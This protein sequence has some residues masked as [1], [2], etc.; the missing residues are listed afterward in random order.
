MSLS[1]S[2]C[3]SSRT[4]ETNW[5]SRDSA[6]VRAG[7]AG[8]LTPGEAPGEPEWRKG[9]IRSRLKTKL[10]TSST[11]SPPMP[12]GTPPPPNPPPPPPLSRRSSISPLTP[13]GVQRMIHLGKGDANLCKIIRDEASAVEQMVC[14]GNVRV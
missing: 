10:R 12:N 4:N 6:A 13:P 9:E 1:Q 5:T 8:R 2:D 3:A 7:S 14:G 11:R